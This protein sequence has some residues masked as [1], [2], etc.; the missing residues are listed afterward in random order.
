MIYLKDSSFAAMS[1]VFQFQTYQHLTSTLTL[2]SMPRDN[3]VKMQV[4]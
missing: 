4:V 1:R 2:S 3:L